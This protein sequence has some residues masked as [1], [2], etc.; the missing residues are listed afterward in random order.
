MSGKNYFIAGIIFALTALIL[1]LFAALDGTPP[2]GLVSLNG[3][4]TVCFT[5]AG[6]NG[7]KVKNGYI[8]SLVSSVMIFIAGLMILIIR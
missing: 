1:S 3:I 6:K 7:C 4:G 2:F 5:N 8:I